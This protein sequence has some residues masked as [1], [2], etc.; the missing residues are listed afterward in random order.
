M[1]NEAN[2]RRECVVALQIRK[3]ER[4]REGKRKTGRMKIGTDREKG[5]EE[6][7]NWQERRTRSFGRD[8]A[9]RKERQN[10]RNGSTGLS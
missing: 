6:R 1:E 5:T 3:R 4:K 8:G 2:R 7:E 10:R 9:E